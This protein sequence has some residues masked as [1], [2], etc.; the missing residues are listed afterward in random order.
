MP[1]QPS[2]FPIGP[3]TT[4]SL[5]QPASTTVQPVNTGTAVLSGHPTTLPHAF[6]TGTL[7]DPVLSLGIWTQLFCHKYLADGTLSRYKARLVANG[8]IQLEGVDVDETFSPVVKPGTIQTILSL[9]ASRHWPIH[10]LDVKNAFLH[11]DLSETRPLY[12][13]KQA[14]QAWFQQHGTDTAYLLLYVDDIVLTASSES[15]LQHIICSLHQEFAMTDLGPLNY[16]MGISFIRDFLGLFLSQKI[17]ALEIL[18]RAHMVNCNPSRTPVDIE[19]KLGDTGDVVSDLTLYRSLAGSLQ[20]LTF[21]RPDISYAVQQ[22]CLYMHDPREP[23]FSALKRILSYVRGTLDYGLQL[24]SFSTT[25]LVAYSDAD[26]AGCPTTRISTSGYCVFLG[27]NL[28]SWS[29]K[30]QPTLSRSSVE[31]EYRGVANV[32]AETCWL[33]NLLRELHTLLTSAT[34]VYCDNVSAVY[35]SCNPVQHQRTKHIKIDIYFVRDLVAAG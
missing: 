6:N 21:T 30:R 2:S 8:S 1:A 33:R 23:H 3:L 4:T 13:L 7:H 29:S 18:D 20:Y 5:T 26:W 22:V 9:A 32:V 16:F 28:L 15:L 25:N 31:A 24:L 11:G 35:L 27:N 14:S 19:S 10:Q 17:Y 12:G 34:L